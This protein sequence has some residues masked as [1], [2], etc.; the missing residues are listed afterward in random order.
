[1]NKTYRIFPNKNKVIKRK[2]E[3]QMDHGPTFLL[4]TSS[5]RI[6]FNSFFCLSRNRLSCSALV[7][8]GEKFLSCQKNKPDFTKR[9]DKSKTRSKIFLPER[10]QRPPS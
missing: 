10:N 7:P 3:E 5:K 1:M 4:R 8:C 2:S 9:E 6:D